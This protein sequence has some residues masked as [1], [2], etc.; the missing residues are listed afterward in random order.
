MELGA[1]ARTE[2]QSATLCAEVKL[3][4]QA[5]WS[6]P[7]AISRSIKPPRQPEAHPSQ[8]ILGKK[9]SLEPGGS[10]CECVDT[11]VFGEFLITVTNLPPNP[12]WF[13]FF[14]YLSPLFL[15]FFFY[16][17]RC[18]CRVTTA[19]IMMLKPY[20][21][22]LFDTQTNMCTLSDFF[23]VIKR[24]ATFSVVRKK[25]PNICSTCKNVSRGKK[26]TKTV[27]VRQNVINWVQT[28]YSEG[29]FAL[30]RLCVDECESSP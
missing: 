17:C 9:S 30:S 4:R 11:C 15:L 10:R 21:S 25:N 12:L 6:A 28:F 3:S 14:S 27:R 19:I 22:Y 16:V 23:C 13:H 7:K 20:F 29:L 24:A 1:D 8:R 5:R 2:R 18:S 26:K